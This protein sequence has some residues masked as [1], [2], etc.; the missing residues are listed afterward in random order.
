MDMYQWALTLTVALPFLGVLFILLFRN[1]PDV[2]E[3]AS[4][5]TA[6]LT[7]LLTAI[8]LPSAFAARPASTP[9]LGMMPGLGL[10]LKIGRAHV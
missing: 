6:V 2:R 9:V 3:G 1:H 7:F 4:L 5:V 8:S 10:Q